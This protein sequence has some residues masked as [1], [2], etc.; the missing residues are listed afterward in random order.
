MQQLRGIVIAGSSDSF[1]FSDS[2]SVQQ[3]AAH[4][5]IGSS[6][7]IPTTKNQ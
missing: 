5:A 3:P 1:L 7:L 4:C 6:K 2:L